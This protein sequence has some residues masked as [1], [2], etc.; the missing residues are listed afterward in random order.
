MSAYGRSAEEP[1]G[2]LLIGPVS[3]TFCVIAAVLYALYPEKEV[4]AEA[5]KLLDTS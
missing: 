1:L 2:V 5:G 4:R 3:G